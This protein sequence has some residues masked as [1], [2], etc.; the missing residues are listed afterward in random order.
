MA[1]LTPDFFDDTFWEERLKGCSES[2]REGYKEGYMEG[3]M[4]GRHEVF[5][6]TVIKMV[7]EMGLSMEEA[8]SI[9]DLYDEE[10]PLVKADVMKRL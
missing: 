3:Y 8:I 5:V 4:E 9:L 2:Y 10:L 6:D 1:P 7:T